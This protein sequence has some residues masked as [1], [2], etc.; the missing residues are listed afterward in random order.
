MHK[1]AIG[2]LNVMTQL[3]T[4]F[5]QVQTAL[6]ERR[7]AEAAV[8]ATKAH[9]LAPQDPM[10][11]YFMAVVAHRMHKYRTAHQFLDEALMQSPEQGAAMLEKGRVYYSQGAFE[12]ALT[13]FNH[14]WLVLPDHPAVA[15]DLGLLLILFKRWKE[16]IRYLQLAAKMLTKDQDLFRALGV[17]FCSAGDIKKGMA[18]FEKAIPG[19]RSDAEWHVALAK[20]Y[21]SAGQNEAALKATGNALEIDK[22]NLNAQEVR[23]AIFNDRRDFHAAYVALDQI[24]QRVPTAAMLGR[25]AVLLA[26]MGDYV[27]SVAAYEQ[28][29][30]QEPDN[31]DIL[32]HY[33]FH[34]TYMDV[35]TPQ[36]SFELHRH[37]GQLL[38]LRHQA[39]SYEILDKQTGRKLRIG[40]VSGDFCLHAFAQ[41]ALPL[42]RGHD[43]A[44]FDIV[45][46]YTKR[47]IDDTTRQFMQLADVWR[48]VEAMSDSQLAALIVD[49][50]I[51]ILVDC[52]VH[53]SG[54][55]L[56]VF[57][58]KPAPIQVSWGGMPTTTG[59]TRIDYRLT[60]ASLDPLGTTECFHTE[61][62]WRLPR[63]TSVLTQ[64][65]DYPVAGPLPALRN[66]HIT[67]AV[68][69]RLAKM[70][71]ISIQFWAAVL[72][73][74]PNSQLML[75]VLP[76]D[77]RRTP[78][79]DRLLGKLA[80]AGIDDC[81]IRLERA[82]GLQ[83]FLVL[84]QEVDIQLDTFPYTGSTTT[85]MSVR[86]G[87][88]VVSLTGLHP[89]TRASFHNLNAIGHPEWV[90]ANTEQA[91]EIA[92]K[93]AG[94]LHHLSELRATL[95]TQAASSPLFDGSGFTRAV[96]AAYRQMWV[97]WCTG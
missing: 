81:R 23:Y 64:D 39:P 86:M 5:T 95:P 17:A 55:R 15:R 20:V 68:F 72:N 79:V 18:A 42:F 29:L 7:V 49:D 97:K 62:L 60:D 92:I 93:L 85:A 4:L 32:S 91:A 36:A 89:T 9:T 84:H 16:A 3:T 56:P 76:T 33:C 69:N 45:C 59:L 22:N 34:S 75:T 27:A 96:E 94:D 6:A 8:L 21:R 73:R 48:D 38:E 35:V 31:L 82:R 12:Q 52:S 47:G 53:T 24:L 26:S 46:Y 1:I 50:R 74:V 78:Q 13:W 65:E 25:K 51:D 40:Y 58:R 61:A 90:G 19:K 11:S 66:G 41:W 54:H 70:S 2:A 63:V 28:A 83:A 10:C 88:P 43:H 30:A 77:G 37:Y 87:V 44:Q 14:A 80:D 57:A 67:F 71:D